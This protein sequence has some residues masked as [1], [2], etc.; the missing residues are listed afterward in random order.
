MTHNLEIRNQT[1]SSNPASQK[2]TKHLKGKR[3]I[4]LVGAS[5]VKNAS[6]NSKINYNLN[7][8]LQDM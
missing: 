5:N 4:I 6:V 1:T 3:K 2:I 7:T 8:K